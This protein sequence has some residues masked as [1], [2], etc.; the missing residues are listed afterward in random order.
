M[1]LDKQAANNWTEKAQGTIQWQT[2][3]NTGTISEGN[4]L[5]S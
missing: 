3:I 2:C 1:A 4:L 5:I